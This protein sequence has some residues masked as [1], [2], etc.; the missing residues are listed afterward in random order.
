ME[1]IIIIILSF[2]YISFIWIIISQ[3]FIIKELRNNLK[4]KNNS[5]KVWLDEEVKQKRIYSKLSN[6]LINDRDKYRK[7]YLSL[8][9][10]YNKIKKYIKSFI[11]WKIDKDILL[12]KIK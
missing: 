10:R 5:F 7:D 8:Y 12:Y 3:Y 11:K 6:A 9:K 2:S 4:L 1:I